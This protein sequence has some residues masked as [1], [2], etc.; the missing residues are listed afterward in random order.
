MSGRADEALFDCVSNAVSA[1]EATAF[2]AVSLA[3]MV[4]PTAFRMASELDRRNVTLQRAAEQF[5]GPNGFPS[6][7]LTRLLVSVQRD[8]LFRDLRSNRHELIHRGSPYTFKIWAAAGPTALAD[9][10]SNLE[11]AVPIPKGSATVIAATTRNTLVGLIG[12][13]HRFAERRLTPPP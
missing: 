10:R 5:S 11:T 13:M 8:P 7:P 12:A 1:L 6:E 3:A 9:T 2:A 4:R